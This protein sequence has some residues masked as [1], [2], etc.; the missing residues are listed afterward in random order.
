MWGRA[1]VPEPTLVVEFL[2][3]GQVA[4][5][6]H[7][8]AVRVRP[9]A[10]VLCQPQHP[11]P[12]QGLQV[13][14][15]IQAPDVVLPQVE[16]AQVLAPAQWL[17][18]RDAIDAVETRSEPVPPSLPRPGGSTALPTSLP[19]N[20]LTPARHSKACSARGLWHFIF[21]SRGKH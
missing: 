19:C 17:E 2:Q 7:A 12:R 13:E 10:R 1:Q 5:H 4:Q 9:A 20:S 11:Q 18:V 8:V 16:L 21:V 3:A 15:L 14:Q 6:G